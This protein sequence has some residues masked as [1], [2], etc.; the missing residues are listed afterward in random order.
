MII[1][2]AVVLLNL[3]LHV[4][5]FGFIHN[6]NAKQTKRNIRIYNEIK[7]DST[8]T[9]VISCETT[10]SCREVR[11]AFKKEMNEAREKKMKERMLNAESII[12]VTEGQEPKKSFSPFKPSRPLPE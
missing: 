1:I 6:F 3:F 11:A 4:N 8:Q 2:V 5:T 12:T 10:G 9:R 7:S